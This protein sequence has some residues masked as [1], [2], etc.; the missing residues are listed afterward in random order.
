MELDE[1]GEIPDYSPEEIKKWQEWSEK[2]QEEKYGEIFPEKSKRGYS[3][4]YLNNKE[5]K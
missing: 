1:L 4:K 5:I 3:R 2:F